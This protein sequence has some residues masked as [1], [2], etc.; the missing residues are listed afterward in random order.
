MATLQLPTCYIR[1]YDSCWEQEGETQSDGDEEL[2]F[3]YSRQKVAK[4]AASTQQHVD[5]KVRS[6]YAAVPLSAASLTEA[7]SPSVRFRNSQQRS[8]C[9]SC[10]SS[11]RWTSLKG[12]RM[13]SSHRSFVTE[14][15]LTVRSSMQC[16]S[17]VA[18]MAEHQLRRKLLAFSLWAARRQ[19]RLPPYVGS[20]IL[21]CSRRL[22]DLTATI[23]KRGWKTACRSALDALQLHQHMCREAQVRKRESFQWRHFSWLCKKGHS[24]LVEQMLRPRDG[25]FESLF[26]LALPLIGCSLLGS[27]PERQY[28]RQGIRMH[29][30]DGGRHERPRRYRGDALRARR[31]PR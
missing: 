1:K 11:L 24:K 15:Q 27:V 26:A 9:K 25:T 20:F 13:A 2:E 12:T 18:C 10:T 22:F 29:C 8:S 28:A 19:P 6:D 3:L 7:C 31:G 21:L 30:S 17:G 16:T 4:T 23:A 5:E 14:R